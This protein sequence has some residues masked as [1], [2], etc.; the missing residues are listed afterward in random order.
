MS[1][2]LI[3]IIVDTQVQTMKLWLLKGMIPHY[4]YE[5]K[6]VD[7]GLHSHLKDYF[8]N[9]NACSNHATSCRMPRPLLE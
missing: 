6:M 7:I 9:E 8:P 4:N 1:V 5:L 2:S 3:K